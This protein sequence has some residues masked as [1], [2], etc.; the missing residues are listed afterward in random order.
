MDNTEQTVTKTV[1]REASPSGNVVQQSVTTE[2]ESD[3]NEFAVA[4]IN[5]IIWY[6][7]AVIMIL[8]GLRFLLLLLAANNTG[9][10]SFIYSL[11]RIFIL[12]FVG[13]F[14]SPTFG[15]SFFDSASLVGIVFYIILG[16]IITSLVNLFSKRTE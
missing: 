15:A 9:I 1:T 3:G 10:V 2:V 14:K 16:F 13:I 7:L 12:P 6:V 4:K 8:L 11:S 5:Q